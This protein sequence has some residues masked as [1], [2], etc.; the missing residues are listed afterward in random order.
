MIIIA[1]DYDGTLNHHGISEADKNAIAKFRE[2]GNKF[3]LVTGRSLSQALWV[4]KDLKKSS[5]EVDFVICCTGGLRLNS[6]GKI[7]SVKKQKI[8]EF[9]PKMVEYAKTLDIGGFDISNELTYCYVD[10]AG[11]IKQDFSG[12]CGEIT[13]AN[14][15]F[16]NEEDAEKF[17]NY[18]KENFSNEIFAFRNG[19]SVDIP[20]YGVSKVSGIYDYAEK[21]KDA[22]IYA[23]GDN[24]NDI[25]MLNEFDSYAV[26]NAREEAKAAA[27]HQCD[28]IADMIEE[29]LK[30]N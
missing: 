22:K 25:P 19:G 24:V 21:Y 4:L 20:P 8:G 18:I 6:E 11:H 5:C 15:W 13:Q 23:V 2:N 16:Y 30:E 17:V 29:I 9:L 1:S 27:K 28:R 10:T 7:E 14:S 3:G 12:L 26:S